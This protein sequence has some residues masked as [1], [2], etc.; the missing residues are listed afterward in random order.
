MA[1]LNKVDEHRAL[2]SDLV[3]DEHSEVQLEFAIN[4][5]DIMLSQCNCMVQHVFKF[6]Q[7]IGY[8]ADNH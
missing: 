6:W 2:S 3:G 4:I 7:H 8:F 5:I 1:N